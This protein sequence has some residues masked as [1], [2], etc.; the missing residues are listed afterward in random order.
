MAIKAS[1]TITLAS[2]TDVSSVTPYYLAQ[3]STL[4]PPTFSASTISNWGT[5][6]PNLDTSK[7]CYIAFLTTFSDNTKDYSSVSTMSEYEASKSAYNL[8]DSA[9]TAVDEVSDALEDA[10]STLDEISNT[11]E[12]HSEIISET[13]SAVESIQGGYVRWDSTTN[14]MIQV[15][16][17]DGTQE[18]TSD[19]LSGWMQFGLD[20]NNKAT[21]SLGDDSGMTVNV[22]PDKLSF[23][24]NG[25]EV[26]YISNQRL[27]ITQS[28]VLQQMDVG[29]QIN[30]GG[31]GQWS[32]KIHEINGGNNLYLKWIG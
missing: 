29:E 23:C 21:L 6:Q 4:S 1:D 17:P 5:T 13:A 22:Q 16:N 7:T 3:T 31:L 27:Y 9:A 19:F 32:W 12:S 18:E 25:I 10:S 24:E 28:V 30:D 20:A 26:A 15:T 8:A 2:V 14:K 11:L